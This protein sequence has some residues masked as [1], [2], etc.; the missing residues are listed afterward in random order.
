MLTKPTTTGSCDGLACSLTIVAF[1]LT[2]P[3]N[4]GHPAGCG[5]SACACACDITTSRASPVGTRLV[6]C[7]LIML[8]VRSAAKVPPASWPGAGWELDPISSRSL[9]KLPAPNWA[10]GRLIVVLGLTLFVWTPLT[11]RFWNA[12]PAALKDE[13]KP[14]ASAEATPR[15]TSAVTNP[16]TRLTPADSET[17]VSVAVFVVGSTVLVLDALSAFACRTLPPGGG[18]ATFRT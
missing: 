4:A 11:T 16:F 15:T 8:T 1:P 7:T 5:K 12:D 17:P 13:L 9:T 18:T 6:M 3:G 10:A 2:V 14:E